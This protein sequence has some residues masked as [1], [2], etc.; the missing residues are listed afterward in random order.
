[1]KFEFQDVSIEVTPT[2]DSRRWY[3]TL[4]ETAMAYGVADSSVRST[5]HRHP[6]EIREGVEKGVAFCN[7]LGGKQQVGVLYREGVIKL[8]FFMRGERA[9]DR[10]RSRCR[11]F[12]RLHR[13]DTV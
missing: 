7:T 2:N 12:F 6:D 3:M 4:E 5:L 1:M 11:R 8:G 13:Q 10:Y 9:K